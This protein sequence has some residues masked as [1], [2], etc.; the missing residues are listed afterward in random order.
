MLLEVWVRV[1][2]LPSDTRSD[3]LSLWGMG[4]LFGKTLNVDMAFT[5]KNKVLRTKIG[6]LDCSLIPANSDVFIRRGFL[7]SILKL[8]ENRELRK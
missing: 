4:T 1:S 3:Y 5:R 7:N 8:R 6:C 2:G